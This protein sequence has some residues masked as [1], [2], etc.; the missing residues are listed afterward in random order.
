MD[1]PLIAISTYGR[2][3]RHRFSLPAEYV[4][5]VRHAGG[6]PLLLPPGETRWQQVFARID[7]LILAGGGDLDP[8]CYGGRQHEH[9]YN[10]DQER[11][12]TEIEAVRTAVADRVPT[13]GICR[14][15]QVINVALGGTLIQHL[16]DVV[17]KSVPHRLGPGQ[18]AIHS[19][20]LEPSSALARILEQATFDCFSSH[21]QALKD[22]AAPL[23]V[24][25]H[26]PDGTIEAVE[27]REHPFLFAVQ[28]HPELGAAKDAIQRRLF[29]ALVRAAARPRAHSR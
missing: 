12:R 13:L 11:D 21:H 3:D 23:T 17:G 22:V 27:M 10:V 4:D 5:A 9:I 8:S 25:G 18:P 2:D 14:G 20:T 19:V 26:A 1:P 28:W 15:V 29:E 7:G 6:I 24:V 16:P